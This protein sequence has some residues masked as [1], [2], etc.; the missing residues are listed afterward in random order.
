M[1]PGSGRRPSGR[2]PGF[3]DR[4]DAAHTSCTVARTRPE[5]LMADISLPGWHQEAGFAA[6]GS[7]E[8]ERYRYVAGVEDDTSLLE[9]LLAKT[10]I[11]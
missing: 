5:S 9:E 4:L 1:T 3:L 10:G 11:S 2:L 7:T 6:G 8:I